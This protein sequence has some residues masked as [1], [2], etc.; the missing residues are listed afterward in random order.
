MKKLYLLLLNNLR[1]LS[2]SLIIIYRLLLDYVYYN[3][4]VPFYGY[5]G[6]GYNDNIE[7]QLF[8]WILL[9]ALLIPTLFIQKREMNSFGN[10]ILETVIII[11][12]VPFTTL[13]YAGIIND[14]CIVLEILMF[15][16]IFIFDGL[17]YNK[18]SRSKTI[19]IKGIDSN[20]IAYVIGF[21]FSAVVLYI[22]YAYTGFR[23][24]FDF[25]LVYDLRA[26]ASTYNLPIIL[27]YM[28]SMSNIVCCILLAFSIKQRKIL[29]S[30]FFLIVQLLSFGIAGLKSYLVLTFAMIALGIFYN[31]KFYKLW[32]ITLLFIMNMITI[33]GLISFY[34]NN[35]IDVI[36]L[37]IRRTCLLPC[38]ITN[39]YVDFFSYNTP[40][41]FRSSFLRHV[42]FQSPYGDISRLIGEM[43]F[44]IGNSANNGLLSDAIANLGYLGV[45][46]FPCILI[47]LFRLFDYC[48][49]FDNEYIVFVLALFSANSIINS[50]I[51]TILLTHGLIISFAML[52]LIKMERKTIS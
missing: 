52:L 34:I 10:I 1:V 20:I 43:Y 40:D 5:T 41:Y 38:L 36:S 45:V 14:I 22:S 51:F 47:M 48:T 16:L 32:T 8:S 49:N 33:F 37:F 26:E 39:A 30:S 15:S 46:V 17:T 28:Y 13:V 44:Y 7:Y 2:I 6:F 9:F 27:S 23:L 18:N 29:L 50:F 31:K 21:V 25:D 4:I 3:I 35:K 19:I 24:N 42:G 12:L 11:Y